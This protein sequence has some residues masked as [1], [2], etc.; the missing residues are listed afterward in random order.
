MR[1]I[2]YSVLIDSDMGA[3]QRGVGSLAGETLVNQIHQKQMIVSAAGDDFIVTFDEG[4]GHGAGVGDHLPLIVSEFRLLR[5]LEGHR[6]GGDHMHQRT[7]LSAGKYQRIQLLFNVGIGTGQDQ[8]AARAA[9]GLVSRS[10]HYVGNRDRIGIDA[11]RHQSGNVRHIHEQIGAN[12]ISNR[13]KSR[14]VHDPRIGREA[15]DNHLGLAFQRQPFHL[16]VINLTG[17]FVQAVLHRPIQSP[18]EI[19]LGTMGEMAAMSQAHAQ[20]GFT[21]IDQRHVNSGVGLRAGMRLYIGVISLEQLLG[22]VDSQLLGDVHELA[23]AVVA[24]AWITFGV[25]VGQ[26]RTLGFKHARAG[27]VFRSNQLDVGFLALLLALQGGPQ[28][29]VKPGNPHLS[30]EHLRPLQRRAPAT[31]DEKAGESWKQKIVL[32]KADDGARAERLPEQS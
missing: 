1:V 29:I 21:R 18:R 14:P 15:G 32:Q 8:A 26:H 13:A 23:A 27:V 6:F 17:G 25:L 19:D 11:C 31:S 22:A 3:T 5:F 30:T 20:D 16:F 9:Q 24:F 7:A 2:G 4:S 28:L 12:L 10:R